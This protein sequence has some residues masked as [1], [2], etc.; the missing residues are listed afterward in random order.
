MNFKTVLKSAFLLPVTIISLSACNE[1][2]T[3]ETNKD[4]LDVNVTR[5]TTPP[6]VTTEP[7]ADVYITEKP[8]DKD[9]TF[10]RDAYAGGLIEIQAAKD[11]QTRATTD[12]VKELANMILSE[13]QAANNK[14]KAMATAKQVTLD[15]NL[16]EK[17]RKD[18]EKLANEKKYEK[19][20][21]DAMMKDHKKAVDLFEKFA[22]EATDADIKAFATATLPAL[23]KHMDMATAS[24]DKIKDM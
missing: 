7:K 4:S 23:R 18:L 16:T 14:I 5:E 10:L 2:T 13:H 12:H 22:V 15:D 17:Q 6:V 9:A 20:F 24:K 8:T 19:Q 3:T 21:A 11:A 1:T